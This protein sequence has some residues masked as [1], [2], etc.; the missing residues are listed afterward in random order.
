[1]QRIPSTVRVVLATVLL[2]GVAAACASSS[3]GSAVSTASAS[4][5]AVAAPVGLRTAPQVAQACMDALMTGT[6]ARHPQSGLGITADDGQSMAVEWPFR[7]SARAESGRILLLDEN[8][9]VVA[10]EGD[11][12]SVGGGFGNAFW[13]ACGPVTVQQP[14]S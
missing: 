3:A 13:H 1:M 2:S 9:K 14:G 10:C 12:I 5:A 6:L 11:E 7:Y 8:G 4:A